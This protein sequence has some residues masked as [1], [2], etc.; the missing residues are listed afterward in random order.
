[1][2]L[3]D[4]I[5]TWVLIQGKSQ[6]AAARHFGLSRNTVAKLLQ[7][8]PEPSERRYHQQAPHKAPVREAVLPQIQSWLKE[9]DWLQRWAPKQRWTAHRMWVELR[10]LGVTVAESTVRQLVREQQ[11]PLKPAYVPLDF[12]PGERAEFDFGEA[13]IK[14]N[15]QLLKV[16]FLA[17]RLRFSGAMFVECFPTQRQDAFLLGQRHA[18]EFWGGVPR[19]AVY[20]N[21]KAAVAQV[22]RGHR[23]L[24]QAAFRHFQS[25]YR[26][27]ALFANVQA[28]W[29]KGSVENLVGYARRNYLVP[30]PEGSNWEAINGVLHQC[31][32]DDQQRIMA[33]RTEPIAARLEVERPYLGPLPE[34]ALEVGPLVEVVVRPTARVRFE[35]NEY[36]VPVRY[37]YQRLSLQADPFRVRLFAGEMLVAEHSRCTALHQVV[38]DWRHYVPLLLEKSFAVPWASALR[39]SDLPEHWERA[40]QELVAQRPDGNREFVRLLELCLTHSVPEVDAALAL[41]RERGGWSADTVRQILHWVQDKAATPPPLDPEQ[42]PA[43]Q[44]SQTLPNLAAYNRLLEVRP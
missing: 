38:E 15:G 4:E 17:G 30:L 43:Y 29:E 13:T 32:L 24:Q 12:A 7:E 19:L 5:R 37:A 27:E 26:F 44:G 42:Y 31:C 18:F 10:K 14:L 40:R 25:V 3:R 22:L 35:T 8:A 23:R 6:R 9:N 28:G 2:A 34:H 11:K 36:S 20:D 16:P 1:M 21:L 33:G 41:A 39:H